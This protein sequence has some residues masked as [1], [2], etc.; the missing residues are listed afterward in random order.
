ML[1]L[2][3]QSLSQQED[4]NITKPGRNTT[5]SCDL[6]INYVSKELYFMWSVKIANLVLTTHCYNIRP[7]I[8][9]FCSQRNVIEMKYMD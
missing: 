8:L 2:M 5:F 4:F 3:L 6:I 7:G 1:F 9:L